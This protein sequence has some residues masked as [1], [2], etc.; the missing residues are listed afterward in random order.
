M[1]KIILILLLITVADSFSIP[2]KIFSIKL[3]MTFREK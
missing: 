3:I 1:F 2:T